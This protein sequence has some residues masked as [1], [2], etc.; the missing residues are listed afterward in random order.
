M[1]LAQSAP[2][3]QLYSAVLPVPPNSSPRQMSPAE[4]E[5]LMPD[6]KLLDTLT[7]DEFKALMP[8]ANYLYSDEPEM[9]SSLHYSQLALLMSCLEFFWE[10]R[11]DFFIA[12]NL[13]IYYS[14]QQIKT[15]DFR[16]PDFFFIKGAERRDRLS[17]V[18]WEESG[19]FPN[20][21]IE[22]LSESTASVDRTTKKKLYAHRFKTPEYFWFGPNTLEFVGFRLVNGDYEPILPN[23]QGHL[24]SEEME[25][26]LGI[27]DR[28]LRYFDPQGKMVPT[29]REDAEQARSLAEHAKLQT[30][31]AKL[32]TEH[33]KLQAEQAKLQAE[34]AKLQTEHARLQTEHARLQTDIAVAL[35][36]EAQVRADEERSRAEK[37]A[38]HLRSLGIDP[39]SL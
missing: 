30:E 27:H 11:D 15:R 37:L 22:L 13:T 4:F 23:A 14:P 25:L 29:P 34:Q 32:Q 12:A 17:W 39:N 7:F 1:V 21:I 33:A 6:I 2:Q 31:Q 38:D 5:A 28:K 35:G 9:E 26:F 24:W 3:K 10:N 8:D 16:G 18:I 36:N 20:V 19:Q